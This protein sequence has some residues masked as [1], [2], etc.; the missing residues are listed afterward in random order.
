MLASNVQMRVRNGLYHY[1]ADLLKN[2]LPVP[3]P[4]CSIFEISSDSVKYVGG[5]VILSL[6][7]SD[8]CF[9]PGLIEY[10]AICCRS[11]RLE[12]Y[13]KHKDEWLQ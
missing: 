6:I 10:K 9:P 4:W 11:K 8:A 2:F 13:C 3:I 1:F 7:S 12:L 5:V